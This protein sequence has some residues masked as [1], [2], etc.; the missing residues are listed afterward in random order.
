M[1]AIEEARYISNLKLERKK[2]TLEKLKASGSEDLDKLPSG[3]VLQFNNVGDSNMPYLP[4]PYQVQAAETQIINLEEQIR[5]NKEGYDHY[6]ALLKLN[7]K[8]FSYANKIMSSNYTLGQF[9]PFLT[10]ALAEYKDNEQIVDY[11]N[12][13]IKRIENKI[14]NTIPLVE[15]PKVYPIAKGTAKKSSIVF[16]A[17]LM[18]SVFAAFL[19]EGLEKNRAQTS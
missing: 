11:L 8:L 18:M 7:E 5:A 10:D 4:L 6:A 19:L 12:A 9:C 2:A 13:Y 15:K 14:A 16:V 3:I 17:S 1:A